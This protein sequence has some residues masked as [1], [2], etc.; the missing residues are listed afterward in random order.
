MALLATDALDARLD[1]DGDLYIGPN[2][3]ELIRGIDGVAQLVAIAIR[4][5]KGEWFLNLDAGVPWIQEILGKKFDAA[6]IRQRLL[7]AVTKVPG[8]VEVLKL[9]V[10]FNASDRTLTVT[11]ALRTE[12]GDTEPDTLEV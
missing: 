4:L 3:P 7:E 2:G 12:F 11:H 10:S 8:V 9:D 6:L 5:W 1:T